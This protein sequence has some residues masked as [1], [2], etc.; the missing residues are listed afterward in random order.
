M[1]AQRF[2]CAL[3]A[4]LFLMP[5]PDAAAQDVAPPAQDSPS[6]ADARWSALDKDSS[7][8][9][10][11]SEFEAMQ[12]DRATQNF[13]RHDKDKNQQL[14]SSEFA[15]IVAK[16]EEVRKRLPWFAR[17]RMPAPPDFAQIDTDKDASLSLQ[18]W[19]DAGK[20]RR[21]KM[22]ERADKDD[23]GTVSKSELQQLKAKMEKL[24]GARE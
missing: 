10:D 12:I 22:F 1:N 9:L 3:T 18:E 7:G 11:A 16:M 21:A 4:V 2:A 14:S 19:L 15:P 5:S 8:Q 20:P 6:E 13:R 17:R 23:S 24:T